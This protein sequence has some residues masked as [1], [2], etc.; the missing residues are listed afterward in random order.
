MSA[1]EAMWCLCPHAP[2]ARVQRQKDHPGLVEFLSQEDQAKHQKSRAPEQHASAQ[3]RHT[4]RDNYGPDTAHHSK[5]TR[6]VI[7][8]A[9]PG[10]LS[11]YAL[12]E[13]NGCQQPEK[14]GQYHMSWKCIDRMHR[15]LNL[16]RTLREGC[17]SIPASPPDHMCASAHLS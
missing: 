2:L 5:R 1:I 6:G 14:R 16:L 9:Q 15:R 8:L 17:P 12:P 7:N 10:H 13:A 11:P 3:C 4:H